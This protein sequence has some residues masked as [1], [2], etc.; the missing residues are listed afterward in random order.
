M[1]GLCPFH[2]EKT[3]S[4]TVSPS[5]NIYKCFGC[6]KGGGPVQ[7][8]MEHDSLTFPEAITALAKKYNI[9]IEYDSQE[10]AAAY[11]EQKKAEESLYI[12]NEFASAYF[13]KN[14]YETQEGK[15][16]AL[17]YFKERGFIESTLQKFDL[18]YAPD[19]SKG[20][21][22]SATKA[23]FKMEYLREVGLSSE[24]GYDFFRSRVMFPIHSVSGKIIA[25]AG[26]TLSNN[27]KQPKYINSPETPIYNKRRILYAMHLAKNEIRKKDNCFIVEG[28]TDVISMHQN[29]IENVVASSGTA[30]TEE[31]VRLV[32]RYTNNITFI[33]DGDAAGI[34]AALRG[35]D[36]VLEN[37]M[38]V[39]L[40]LLPEGE[41]PDSMA[42]KSGAEE[43]EKYIDEHSRDFIHFKTD[44]L[45]EQAG[46]DPVKKAELINDIIK[47]LSKVRDPIKRSLYTREC[48]QTLDIAENLLIREVNKA[49][50]EDIRQKRLQREREERSSLGEQAIREAETLPEQPITTKQ[51]LDFNGS[52]H[53]YQE[54]DLARI[55]VCAGD[56]MITTDDDEKIKVADFIYSN[57]QEV[58][59]HFD[60]Q[61]YR[62]II[63]E[64]FKLSESMESDF[65]GIAAHFINHDDENIRKFAIDC[66]SS[67][68]VFANWEIKDI[69][70]QTQKM[71]EENFYK[72]S[73]QSILRFKLKKISKV[74]DQLKTKSKELSADPEKVQLVL[75][76]YQTLSEQ[77]KMIATELGTV[78]P[79]N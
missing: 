49:I 48:S 21:I 35:L 47:S 61:M 12:V 79:G 11:E 17:S 56:K 32:K 9:D 26:R 4:F 40:V 13:K 75:K 69:Y 70:L 23:Q 73:L 74:I 37:D 55:M 3:P 41:D 33:Y 5:K 14:L 45:L 30:L 65:N 76:A 22:E 63:D 52:K 59:D 54:K 28:Y 7:F 46:N 71:P 25:F 43:F 19:N 42:Q 6:G 2:D 58:I 68:Y 27:K 53:L 50:K 8:L 39:R 24:K 77:R 10:D 64:A 66:N 72:D 38:N 60:N 31:Q 44:L 67:P 57:I 18:G 1:I 20:L 62:D 36:I 51:K 16:I 78:V 34:K 29:G 15:V